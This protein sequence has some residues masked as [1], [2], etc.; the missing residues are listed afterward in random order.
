MSDQTTP[1]G[2]GMAAFHRRDSNNPY[3]P[4]S[5]EHEDWQKGYDAA[6]DGAWDAWK[7]GL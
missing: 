4:G 7:S 2:E 5:K 3:P 1:F 6:S